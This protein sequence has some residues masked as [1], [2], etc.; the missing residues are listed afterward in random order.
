MERNKELEIQIQRLRERLKVGI[1][2]NHAS[3]DLNVFK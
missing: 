1:Q 2:S 3:I